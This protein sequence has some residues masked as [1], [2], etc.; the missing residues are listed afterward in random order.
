[1]V[2]SDETTQGLAPGFMHGVGYPFLNAKIRAQRS[3]AYH[4]ERLAELVSRRTV[5]ELA[6]DLYPD[7]RF[8]DHLDLERRLTV[9]HVRQLARLTAFVPGVPGELLGWM[10]QRYQIENLKVLLRFVATGEQPDDWADYLVPVPA[11]EPVPAEDLL[12]SG[13]LSTFV[14]RVQRMGFRDL[15]VALARD[16]ELATRPFTIEAAW[17]L[18]YYRRLADVVGRVRGQDRQPVLELVG[19]EIDTYA[20]LFALRARLNYAMEVDEIVRLT[21]TCGRRVRAK[22]IRQI[23]QCN[24]LDGAAPAIP[25]AALGGGR[26]PLRDIEDVETLLWD[27]TCRLAARM[28]GSPAQGPGIVVAFFYLK[29]VELMN[30]IRLVELLRYRASRD[31]IR[32]RLIPPVA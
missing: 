17:D 28:F 29:R 19:H 15:C 12:S 11:A 16:P 2:T 23:A 5:P 24:D 32:G 13:D 10:L 8:A 4:K 14:R 1:M 27:R 20:V 6:Q 7:Q 31:E 26:G 30:L 3:R 9:D 18:V 25:S 21:P 22:V